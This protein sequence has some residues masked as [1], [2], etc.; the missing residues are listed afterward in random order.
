MSAAPR[1]VVATLLRSPTDAHAR[2]LDKHGAL[3]LMLL[4]T[5][6]GVAGVA[7]E[8]TRL[9]PV[10]GLL[11]FAAA[12]TVSPYRAESFRFRM[13]PAFDRWAR[14]WLQDGDH[15]ISSFGYANECFRWA[16]QHGGK[17]FV[18]AGNSHP[19]NFWEIM[20]EEHQRWNC[21]TPP[22]PPHWYD[23]SVRMMDLT[24]YVIAPSQYVAQSFLARGFSDDQVLLAPYP[25]DLSC[26]K[27]P[28][29][30]RPKERPLTIISTGMLSLRKGTPYLLEAF[31]LVLKRHPSAR[32]VLLRSIH[33]SVRSVMKR[34]E[35]LPISW[36]EP[37]SHLEL[38]GHLRAADVFVLP[39]LEE[40]MVR[41]ALEAM[42]CG[43]PVVLTPNTGANDF[44]RAG[45]NGTIVPLRDSA[46]I[47]DALL[48]WGD[49]I[50]SSKMS[51]QTFVDSDRL[52]SAYFEGELVGE[53][54]RHRL[55]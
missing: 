12:K 1:F 25:V 30:P 53:L 5:R 26:F 29:E 4:G 13:L 3:R 47:R 35:D 15:V 21:S 6:R 38:A 11:N 23:R 48:E 7:D 24:D 10:F 32:L 8:R 20:S 46:A 39:S 14:R 51:R 43:L 16:R 52:S 19:R 28:T 50:L 9:N 40:G 41:T 17:T 34:F 2:V 55:I 33:D 54:Q 49:R 37:C 45:E 18:E 42:A 31:R 27:P 22:M 44:V 36:V